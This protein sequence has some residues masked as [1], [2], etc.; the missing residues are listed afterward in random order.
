ME[1]WRRVAEEEYLRGGLS[2]IIGCRDGGDVDDDTGGVI[3]VVSHA[4]L[5]IL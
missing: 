4:A 2:C 1:V 5:V 3:E